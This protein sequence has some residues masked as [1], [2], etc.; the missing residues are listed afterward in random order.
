[1]ATGQPAPGAIAPVHE[2]PKAML[3]RMRVFAWVALAF[4]VVQVLTGHLG[5]FTIAGIVISALALRAVKKPNTTHLRVFSCWNSCM[6]GFAIA[7]G[8]AALLIA[9][10]LLSCACDAGCVDGAYDVIQDGRAWVLNNTVNGTFSPSLAWNSSRA[11]E[12]S[13]PTDAFF[14]GNGEAREPEEDEDDRR[15][16]SRTV[17]HLR[18]PADAS[19]AV[20]EG[21][22]AV[23]PACPHAGHFG[24]LGGMIGGWLRRHG[25]G[26]RNG[27]GHG[28]GH[29]KWATR[30]GHR[31]GAAP[32]ETED[33]GYN[34]GIVPPPLGDPVPFPAHDGQGVRTLRNDRPELPPMVAVPEEGDM[35]ILPF[36]VPGEGEGEPPVAEPLPVPGMPD[37]RAPE[38]AEPPVW[39]PVRRHFSPRHHAGMRMRH[40]LKSLLHALFEPLADAPHHA[41][42]HDEAFGDH[43]A[44][45][46]EAQAWEEG[47]P[48]STTTTTVVVTPR[49]PAAGGG[50][51]RRLIAMRRLL[52]TE[53]DAAAPTDAHRNKHYAPSTH[54]EGSQEQQQ[55]GAPG[56]YEAMMEERRRNRKYGG[57][58]APGAKRAEND[59]D[60]DGRSDW[61]GAAEGI[62]DDGQRA[63]VW[64]LD[65]S[66][67]L[68]RPQL[69]MAAARLCTA[70]P[71][72]MTV[73]LSLLGAIATFHMTAASVARKLRVHPWYVVADA[74]RREEC[75]ARRAARRGGSGGMDVTHLPPA[76][77]AGVPAAT[78]PAVP[79]AS[80][81]PA[82]DPTVT[83]RYVPGQGFVPN[84]APAPGAGGSS[85]P[86]RAWSAISGLWRSQAGYQR[87]PAV[88]ADPEAG[89]PVAHGGVEMTHM[90]HQGFAVATG[91][92]PRVG[93]ATMP[94]PDVDPKAP[95]AYAAPAGL[96]PQATTM[97]AMPVVHVATGT[98]LGAV[99]TG[100]GHGWAVAGAPAHPSAYTYAA[101]PMR[102]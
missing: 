59:W 23:H 91:A 94:A 43:D 77:V 25:F 69:H 67:A 5:I 88:A 9:T 10:P 39:G 45:P 68:T 84:A 87:V 21:P 74:R 30:T 20:V 36:P 80:P 81:A 34:T 41:H 98:P 86:E 6:A 15:R 12:R 100:V 22:A 26:G 96:Y 35:H 85:V 76:A 3:S 58:G 54:G 89:A 49:A 93:G 73:A 79:I 56:N 2:Q 63:L 32:V 57:G 60:G 101:V 46:E 78:A 13:F 83:Y 33:G 51:V 8:I 90:H 29:G 61:D 47:E 37:P 19:D 92:G 53:V 55:P 7:A 40:V 75:A 11:A 82:A 71:W 50:G 14:P 95:I 1:M 28:H 18:Q 64:F 16:L 72:L 24:K 17:S 44:R 42:P 65:W 48:D 27:H 97:A 66:G 62:D 4:N 52:S 70:G 31:G 99:A 38:D 102:P